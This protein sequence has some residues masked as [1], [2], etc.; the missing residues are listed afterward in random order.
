MDWKRKLASRKF[1]ACITAVVISLIAFTGANP[2]TTERIVALI[3]AIGGL[4][5]YMLSEG[6]ADSKPVDVKVDTKE[7]MEDKE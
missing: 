3:G 5:I 7:V 4:S 1:W 6:L 2:E